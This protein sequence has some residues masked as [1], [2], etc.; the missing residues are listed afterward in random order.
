[1]A[2]LKKFQFLL[3]ISM[4]INNLYEDGLPG[5]PRTFFRWQALRVQNPD[6]ERNEVQRGSTTGRLNGKMMENEKC[7]VYDGG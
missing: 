1:M 7:H 5:A 6:G 3:D 4:R 2:Q